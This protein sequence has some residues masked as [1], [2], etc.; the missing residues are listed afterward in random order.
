MVSAKSESISPSFEHGTVV[1]VVTA[2]QIPGGSS[3]SAAGSLARREGQDSRGGRRLA[4]H[5]R[6]VLSP[7]AIPAMWADEDHTTAYTVQVL[8]F[9]RMNS[10][11]S[12]RCVI[13]APPPYQRCACKG[14]Y[15]A[16]DLHLT[17]VC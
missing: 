17:G 3:N 8:D 5:G 12:Y 6:D 1:T 13:S 11:G 4:W 9:Q 14:L 10:F 16:G 2:P 7:N 15:R